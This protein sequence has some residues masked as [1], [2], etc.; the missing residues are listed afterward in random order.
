MLNNTVFIN[1]DSI[2]IKFLNKYVIDG[3]DHKSINSAVNSIKQKYN[4]D[5]I[6]EN[7]NFIKRYIFNNVDRYTLN[8]YVIIFI[9]M[10]MVALLMFTLFYYNEEIKVK[11]LIGINFNIILFD[12]LKSISVLILINT[13]FFA[14][15]YLIIYYNFMQNI[16]L[17][18]Y[19]FHLIAFSFAVLIFM[20][21]IIYLYMLISNNFF[22]RNGVK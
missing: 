2:N 22:Y 18:F 10:L 5:I 21:L 17:N 14:S 11:R 16:H 1:L 6:K 20:S 15:I 3:K 7:N 12:L 8:V 4:V 9:S 19:Y 13:A